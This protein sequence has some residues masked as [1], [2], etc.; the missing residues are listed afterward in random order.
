MYDSDGE[1]LRPWAQIKVLDKTRQDLAGL[2]EVIK[3]CLVAYCTRGHVLLEGNPGLGKTTLAKQLA[4][5]ISLPWGRIQF[6]P[7]LM[8]SDITGTMLPDYQSR[9]ADRWSFDPGPVFT[10]LLLA[11]EINRA[12]PKTQAALLEAMAESQVTVLGQTYALP[13]PF[14]VL[15]TQNPIDQVGTYALPEAQADRFMF[16]VLMPI[17]GRDS[18]AQILKSRHPVLEKESPHLGS[19]RRAL[20]AICNPHI[21]KDVQRTPE[22]NQVEQQY[23][24]ARAQFRRHAAEIDNMAM[25]LDTAQRKKDTEVGLTEHVRRHLL[26]MFLAS[27]GRSDELEGMRDDQKK[28]ADALV[29]LFVYGLG[30]RAAINL[31]R[32][33]RAWALLFGSAPAPSAIGNAEALAHVLVPILRHRVKLEF[34]W[35]ERYQALQKEHRAPYQVFRPS[36]DR[37]RALVEFI[38]DFCVTTAPSDGQANQYPLQIAQGLADVLGLKLR[39]P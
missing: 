13:E 4:A 19:T 38:A 20:W 14:L 23:T 8:P 6:T 34:D 1:S 33:T 3:L 15:A 39:R 17:P 25:P 10:S 28:R 5:A 22:F 27:N 36:E 37:Q 24:R 2:D 26:N 35:E 12:T 16:K 31:S 11:D 29:K 30:P 7:D 18:V 32:A 21:E 9:S